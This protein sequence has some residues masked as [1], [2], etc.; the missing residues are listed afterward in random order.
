MNAKPVVK[1]AVRKVH[2]FEH[3]LAVMWAGAEAI[4]FEILIFYVSVGLVAVG[5][6]IEV[7]QYFGWLEEA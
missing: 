4:K 7:A 1:K 6:I 5:I 3:Y 2:H